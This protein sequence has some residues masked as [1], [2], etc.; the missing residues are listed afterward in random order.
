MPPIPPSLHH[1][2]LTLTRSLR[3]LIHA[4]AAYD[5]LMDLLDWFSG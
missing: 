3:W 4:H 1:L 2:W 5:T